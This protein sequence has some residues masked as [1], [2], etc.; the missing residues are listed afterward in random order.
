MPTIGS[1]ITKMNKRKPLFHFILFVILLVFYGCSNKKSDEPEHRTFVRI[2]VDN[3][4]Y[5][6]FGDEI[7]REHLVNTVGNTV[8]NLLDTTVSN[9]QGRPAFFISYSGPLGQRQG[10]FWMTWGSLGTSPCFTTWTPTCWTTQGSD[11]SKRRFT[12]SQIS[13]DNKSWS[14][15]FLYEATNTSG[16]IKTVK[17]TYS[18]VSK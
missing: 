9:L 17:G 14:G 15:D 5:E 11:P 16:V 18:I 10:D 13:S 12:V 4:V 7:R 8:G 2:E 1:I 3:Q 6:Y